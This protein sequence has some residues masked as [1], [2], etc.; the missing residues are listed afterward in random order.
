MEQEEAT[1]P[2]VSDSLVDH[3]YTTAN[4]IMEKR[5]YMLRVSRPDVAVTLEALWVLRDA[6]CILDS[7]EEQET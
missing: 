3:T 5:G 6:L 7:R 2:R 1:I 4:L